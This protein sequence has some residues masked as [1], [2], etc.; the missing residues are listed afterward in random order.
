MFGRHGWDGRRRRSGHRRRGCG[1]PVRLLREADQRY[2]DGHSGRRSHHC[3]RQVQLVGQRV[4]IRGTLKNTAL[5]S[6]VSQAEAIYFAGGGTGTTLAVY[7]SSFYSNQDT[8][9]TSGVNWFYKCHIEGNCDFIWGTAQTALF[10]DCDMR[11]VNDLGADA[12]YSL[13]VA[14]TGSTV[15]EGGTGSVGKG[16][17]LSNSAVSVDAQVTA[18][19]GRDAGTGAYYDQAALVNVTF[20]GDGS[21]G[22]GLWK[23]DTAPL[24]MGDG[25]YVGWKS[26]GCTGLNLA[27]LTTA[28]GTS[29]TIAEQAT[30]YDTHHHILDRMV[31][32]T[33]G[34]PSG[35]E[36]VAVPW[37]VTALAVAWGAP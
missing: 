3:Q 32:V 36:P 9:Q 27:S 2:D 12:S 26:A 18:Y 31:T 29:A 11:V 34:E 16:Y 4:R 19:F 13:V 10:E 17:V 33:A 14:R 6:E 30:E 15:A 7:N 8:V 25:S 20:A 23:M 22:E 21:I 35:Y 28:D 1:Q 37:D 5:R 24:S